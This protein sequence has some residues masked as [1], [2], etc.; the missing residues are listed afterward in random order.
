MVLY[1][2]TGVRE[3]CGDMSG[4]TD[5]VEVG[6]GTGNCCEEGHEAMWWGVEGRIGDLIDALKFQF[7]CCSVFFVFS[8]S[9]STSISPYENFF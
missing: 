6:Q 8:L 2:N 1:T 7:Q 9:L 4:T 5:I 3:T